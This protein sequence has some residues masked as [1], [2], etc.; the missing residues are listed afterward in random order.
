MSELAQT[1]KPS[2]RPKDARYLLRLKE[3]RTA[4]RIWF[5]IMKFVPVILANVAAVAASPTAPLFSKSLGRS[6]AALTDLHTRQS[7]QDPITSCA[8]EVFNM[9][10]TGAAYFR[11]CIDLVWPPPPNEV[12][13]YPAG[14]QSP[15]DIKFPLEGPYYEFPLVHKGQLSWMGGT[16]A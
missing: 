9:E 16:L 3:S 6:A 14:W 12:M 4:A 15:K 1:I 11:A 8:G 2:P 13:K 5:T 7:A 10:E